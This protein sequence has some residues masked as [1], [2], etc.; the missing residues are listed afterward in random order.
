MY[1][2]TKAQQQAS[3]RLTSRFTHAIDYAR[4][5]HI[6][7]RKKTEV[8]YIAHLLGVASL[9]MGE[10]GHVPFRVTED[11]A[12]AALLHDAVEDEGGLDRLRDIE[13]NFGNEVAKIVEGCS[14]SLAEDSGK[15]AEWEPRKKQYLEKLRSEPESTLLVS[16]AD[17]L[18]N[19]RAMVE[20]FRS[21]GA[22]FWE[23][24]K[25]GTEP[26]LWYYKEV[27]KVYQKRC[28]DWRIVGEVGRA[29]DQLAQLSSSGLS[30]PPTR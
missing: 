2:S 8:P 26:Q 23:R 27:L 25:R 3:L 10:T 29:I 13:S 6:G 21:E 12:I 7:Y 11:M 30:K 28:P 1:K 22:K 5:V 16:A 20:D 19:V 18:H 17:K 14:D 9:V 15:K 24:F 4:H